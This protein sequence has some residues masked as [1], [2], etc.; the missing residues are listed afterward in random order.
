MQARDIELQRAFIPGGVAPAN[1]G[2]GVVRAENL[3]PQLF[4]RYIHAELA[5]FVPVNLSQSI[6][7]PIITYMSDLEILTASAQINGKTDPTRT[8]RGL[9][10]LIDSKTNLFHGSAATTSEQK[11][12]LLRLKSEIKESVLHSQKQYVEQ[13][14]EIGRALDSEVNNARRTQAKN[15][16]LIAFCALWCPIENVITFA[17]CCFTSCEEGPSASAECRRIS[18]Q[19]QSGQVHFFAPVTSIQNLVQEIKEQQAQINQ[20]APVRQMMR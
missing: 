9:L 18:I 19:N 8:Y 7:D 15:L 5:K 4:I 13:Q 20:A 14:K 10:E 16:A 2:E 3:F 1:E 12:T 11:S 17:N 6:I